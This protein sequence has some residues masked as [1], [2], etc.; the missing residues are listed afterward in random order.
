MGSGKG[1][2]TPKEVGRVKGNFPLDKNVT[3]AEEKFVKGVKEIIENE[4]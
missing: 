1:N 2:K 4:S 3:D